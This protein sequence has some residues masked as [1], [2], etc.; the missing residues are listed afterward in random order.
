M[1]PEKGLYVG[2]A[3]TQAPDDFKREVEGVKGT[4]RGRGYDILEFVGSRPATPEE[5][6][7]WD[8]EQCVGQCGAM[9][10]IADYPS[11][12]L[13]WEMATAS[14]LN[15]PTLAVA[16]IGRTVTRLVLGAA[17]AVPSFEFARYEDL[18][19]VPDRLDQFL[20]RH[21]LSRYEAELV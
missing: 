18:Q 5:V 11:L 20:G 14:N 21:L 1:K 8:I 6:Y 4:L 2:C 12:G 10:A 9:L 19:D 13:G 16:R 3:L 15:I 7:R 17:E